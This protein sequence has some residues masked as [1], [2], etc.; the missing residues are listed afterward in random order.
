MTKLKKAQSYIERNETHLHGFLVI[1]NGDMLVEEYYEGYHADRLHQLQSAT[2]TF[3]STLIGIAIDKKIIESVDQPL[4]ELLPDHDHWFNEEKRTITLRQT[5]NMT[6]GLEWHDWRNT[7]SGK[8]SFDEIS[9][10]KDSVQYI[11]TQPLVSAPG[12]VFHYNTGSSH[13]LSAILHYRSGMTTAQFAEKYLFR[14]LEITNYQWDALPDG[15]HQGGWGLHLTPQD[16]AK[17][18]QLFLNRGKWDDEQ[19]ISARWVEQATAQQVDIR[20]YSGGYGFQWWIPTEY[21]N[22]VAAAMGYGGQDIFVLQDLNA[23]VVFTGDIK[24]PDAGIDEPSKLLKRYILSA[25]PAVPA[26]SHN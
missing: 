15:V 21:G 4:C 18:G 5:L 7:P 17:L 20:G 2:K 6:T 16:M 14:P 24:F 9:V 8:S 3:L 23:V 10:A 19:V 11:L 12:E 22:N 25:L 1:H 26:P 13:L